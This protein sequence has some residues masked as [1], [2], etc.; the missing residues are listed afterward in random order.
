MAR[1]AA[2]AASATSAWR[3]VTRWR[4]R[5]AVSPWAAGVELLARLGY[6]A[7]GVVYLSIGLIALLAVAG[8]A[9]HAGPTAWCCCG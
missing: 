7:R 1:S 3:M 6:V 8:L 2:A 9:P 4:R 5:F